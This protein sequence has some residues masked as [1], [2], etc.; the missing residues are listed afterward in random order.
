M[1]LAAHQPSYLPLPTLFLKMHLA[2]VFV[3]ADD[4]QYS[5]HNFINRTKIKTA[6]GV[7]W[8]TVPVRTKGRAGQLINEVEIDTFQDWNQKHW[9]TLLVNYKYAAYFERYAD[10]FESCYKKPWTRLLELNLEI[11][12]FIVRCLNISTRIHLSS[13]LN[14]RGKGTQRL[15]SILDRLG[16]ESYLSDKNGEKYLDKQA[17]KESGL[18]LTF[19]P[20]KYPI[21]HQQFGGF[22]PA[23]SIVDL[24]FN[25]GDNSRK[26]LFHE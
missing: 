17:F 23:L 11:I 21:Y 26:I 20:S 4:I 8:L 12:E 6:Q 5:K 13:E 15:I 25:E 22:E 7:Q 2:D 3:L 16:C 1:I 24:L 19:L 14:A 10:F 9:K 18:K